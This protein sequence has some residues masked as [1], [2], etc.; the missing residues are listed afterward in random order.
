MHIK[1][2]EKRSSLKTWLYRITVNQCKDYLKSY[3]I[4]KIFLTDDTKEQTTEQTPE[5][6]TLRKLNDQGIVDHIMSLPKKYREVLILRFIHEL[7]S[8]EIAEILSVPLDTVKTR[9]RRAKDKLR[10]TLKEEYLNEE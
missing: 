7:E 2:F 6:I 8:K 5:T 9:I 4:R 10:P 1:G 3:Y